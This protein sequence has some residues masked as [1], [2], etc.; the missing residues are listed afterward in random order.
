MAQREVKEFI[1]ARVVTLLPTADIKTTNETFKEPKQKKWYK[2]SIRVLSVRT[3]GLGSSHPNNIGIFLRDG[4]LQV[5]GFTPSGR[6]TNTVTD[7]LELIR[8]GFEFQHFTLSSGDHLDFE[9]AKGPWDFGD[10]DTGK[11]QQIL[12]LPFVWQEFPVN[13]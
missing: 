6:G 3:A 5:D 12:E 13:S 11:F 4:I 8:K 9:T 10:T 7:N 2:V 1:E